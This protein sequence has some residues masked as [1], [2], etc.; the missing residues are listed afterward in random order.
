MQPKPFK[1][2]QDNLFS[3][4]LSWLLNR[5]HE[6]LKLAKT[7]PWQQ[8]EEE[9]KPLFSEG[10]SRPPLSVRLAVGLMI[11]QHMFAVSDERVVEA[12]VENPYWEAFCGYDFLQ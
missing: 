8:L 3:S 5:R 6:L 1:Q 11:L 10:P 9:F 12:W 7:I 4:R 2:D